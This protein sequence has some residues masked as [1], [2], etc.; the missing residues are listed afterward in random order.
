MQSFFRRPIE[1]RPGRPRRGETMSLT[2]GRELPIGARAG[3]IDPKHVKAIGSARWLYDW[4]LW[5]V[6]SEQDGLGRVLGGSPVRCEE[7]A[8]DLGVGLR[9][10]YRWMRRLRGGYIRTRHVVSYGRH[11]LS[12]EVL[13]SKKFTS[14]MAGKSGVPESRSLAANPGKNRRDWARDDRGLEQQI[15][16]AYA[17]ATTGKRA[18]DERGPRD[19]GGKSPRFPQGAREGWGT[20][21]GGPS[22]NSQISTFSTVSTGNPASAGRMNPAKVGRENLANP[23][24]FYKE[25]RN[26]LTESYGKSNCGCLEDLP[27]EAGFPKAKPSHLTENEKQGKNQKQI[28]CPVEPSGA[29]RACFARNDGGLGQQIPCGR[30]EAV[31]GGPGGDGA[32]PNTG[33]TS[34]PRGCAE[35]GPTPAPCEGDPGKELLRELRRMIRRKSM[36]REVTAQRRELLERQRNEL[37][38][39]AERRCLPP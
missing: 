29:Q 21:A 33:E 23:G 35:T 8:D 16:P 6:T 9:T 38:R 14:G 7:I 22:G 36:P 17:A 10:V 39:R 20:R 30:A 3:L 4:I 18:A 26:P 25:D 32:L 1:K 12:I 19:D 28:P 5:R 24:G 15:P 11:G 31:A 13:R 27:G 37:L 2:R 34:V